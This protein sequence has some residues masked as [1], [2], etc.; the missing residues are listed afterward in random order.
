MFIPQT[1]PIKVSEISSF[2]IK[3][4]LLASIGLILKSVSCDDIPDLFRELILDRFNCKHLFPT[5]RQFTEAKELYLYTLISKGQKYGI[6]LKSFAEKCGYSVAN[7]PKK[8]FVFFI[9]RPLPLQVLQLSILEPLL[10]PLP[11]QS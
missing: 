9:I 1:S 11:S 7:V 6:S 4:K 5:R 2:Y 8:D 3:E 10:A